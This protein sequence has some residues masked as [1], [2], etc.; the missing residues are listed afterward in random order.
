MTL[1]GYLKS[2]E[3]TIELVLS[4]YIDAQ[5]YVFDIEVTGMTYTI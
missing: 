2:I 5:L 3:N 4:K 1:G